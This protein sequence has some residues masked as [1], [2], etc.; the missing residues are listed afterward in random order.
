MTTDTSSPDTH[1]SST[2]G[3]Q[4]T[5]SRPA[6][7]SS[8]LAMSTAVLGVLLLVGLTGKYQAGAAAVAGG[9]L[10]AGLTTLV[11]SERRLSTIAASLLVAP[12]TGAV[13]LGFI[14]PV[15]NS[16]NII[17]L[18]LPVNA[19]IIFATFGAGTILTG[20]LGGRAVY[21]TAKVSAAVLLVPAITTSILLLGHMDAVLSTLS[22]VSDALATAGGRWVTP[23]V[24]YPEVGGFLLLYAVAARAIASSGR[25]LPVVQLAA[26][27]DRAELRDKLDRVVGICSRTAKLALVVGVLLLIVELAGGMGLILGIFPPLAL[28]APITNLPFIRG[29]FLLV[30]VPLFAVTW[31]VKLVKWV[32]TQQGHETARNMLR[33]SAGGLVVTGAGI[34]FTTTAVDLLLDRL[35][36]FLT[37][38]ATGAIDAFSP[39]IAI[40]GLIAAAI[41]AFTLLLIGISTLGGMGFFSDRV[42]SGAVASGALL[43]GALF[44]GALRGSPFLL[45]AVVVLAIVTWDVSDYGATIVSELDAGASTYRP[46][47]VH[48]TASG[49]VGVVGIAIVFLSRAVD[50]AAPT[51][52]R[53]VVSVVAAAFGAVFLA[54]ILRG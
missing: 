38:L 12:T 44:A 43:T 18:T 51:G 16:S 27:E 21:R 4:P 31:T 39:R 48:A 22:A 52:S 1:R 33:L 3:G 6:R 9:A 8:L 2:V 14:L 54:G 23:P 24:A 19:A 5:T 26:R 53:V 25:T 34:A 35:P 32:V 11:E 47:V 20:A 30:A 7:T 17:P 13:A 50:V 45:F 49:V 42:A 10:L 40:L 28:I 29:L 46:E 15:A 37:P 41:G 36:S